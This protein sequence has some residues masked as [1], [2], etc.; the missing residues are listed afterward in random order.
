M[1][2]REPEPSLVP[3]ASEHASQ[4][5]GNWTGATRTISGTMDDDGMWVPTDTSWIPDAFRFRADGTGENIAYETDYVCDTIP[6]GRGGCYAGGF[7]DSL[8][9]PRG[10]D[11]EYDGNCDYTDLVRCQD[12]FVPEDTTR[13]TWWTSKGDLYLGIWGFGTT[14]PPRSFAGTQVVG[15][16]VAGDSL[17]IQAYFDHALM[18]AYQRGR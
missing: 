18:G 5:A 3:T 11:P 8:T 6:L 14:T 7:C 16:S 12:A 13:F 15:W 4:L 9:T 17:R 10:C 2:V 1:F